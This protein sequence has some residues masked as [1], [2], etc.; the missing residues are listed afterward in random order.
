MIPISGTHEIP[1]Y[2]H[3]DA[4]QVMPGAK[5]S[6][7]VV[8]D[9]T[10][11]IEQASVVTRITSSPDDTGTGMVTIRGTTEDVLVKCPVI[12]EGGSSVHILTRGDVIVE[13]PTNGSSLFKPR[14]VGRQTPAE[15][16]IPLRQVHSVISTGGSVTFGDG[17]VAGEFVIYP[18]QLKS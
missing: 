18:S 9:Q 2:V 8:Q 6:E 15:L 3:D 10:L 11:V 17:V 1:I 5:V 4:A 13:P 12:L 14:K 7:I 16:P